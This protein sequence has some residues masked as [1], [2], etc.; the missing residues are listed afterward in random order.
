MPGTRLSMQG[1]LVSRW[2]VPLNGTLDHIN[3]ATLQLQAYLHELVS[4]HHI[5]R[6]RVLINKEQLAANLERF[7]DVRRLAG[8]A[9]GVQRAEVTCV[10]ACIRKCIRSQSSA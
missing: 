5:C 8:A 3:I 10:L 2:S 7:D 9:R 1:V 4:D 6:T